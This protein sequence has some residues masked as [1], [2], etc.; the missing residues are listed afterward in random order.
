[1]LHHV[2]Y[3]Y[4]PANSIDVPLAF[5][6]VLLQHFDR[7][8]LIGEQVL[9]EDDLAKGAFSERA[10]H[11]VIAEYFVFDVFFWDGVHRLNFYRFFVFELVDEIFCYALMIALLGFGRAL[12]F[13]LEVL[14]QPGRLLDVIFGLQLV[15]ALADVAQLYTVFQ[16]GSLTASATLLFALAAVDRGADGPF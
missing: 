5:D 16:I 7:H 2:K 4:L 8:F 12:S 1:M 11:S 10:F 14:I 15:G 3:L 9:A 13:H 6:P